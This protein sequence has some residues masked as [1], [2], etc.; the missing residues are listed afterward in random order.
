[1]ADMKV[2]MTLTVQDMGTVKL[3]QFNDALKSVGDQVAALNDRFKAAIAGASDF[4]KATSDAA[5]G[6]TTLSR[7]SSGAS[8]STGRLGD[9]L[10]AMQ[11]SLLALNE[12]LAAAVDNIS[13]MAAST[14]DL[15]AASKGAAAGIAAVGD[16]AEGAGRKAQAAHGS[17]KPLVELFA[18]FKGA[19]MTAGADK[20]ASK[21]QQSMLQLRLRNMTPEQEG[22]AKAGARQ[23]SKL[24]FINRQQALDAE[25]ISQQALPGQSQFSQGLRAKL[26]P[27][28]AK[29]AFITQ[30]Y[31]PRASF[32]ESFGN[33][34]GIVD[35]TG[36]ADNLQRAQQ[37]L[38]VIRAALI[39]TGGKLDW[40]GIETHFR[41]E[42]AATRLNM[43][44][45]ELMMELSFMDD[46][47]AFG[48]AGAG[49]NTRIGT[50]ANN[51]RTT[52][53]TGKIG[54][55]AAVMLEQLR[56]LKASDTFIQGKSNSYVYL[57]PDALRN[58]QHAASSPME[59]IV[60]TLVPR[61]LRYTQ[62]HWKQFGYK[63]P[64]A[65]NFYNP[66]EASAALASAATYFASMGAG[67][68]Q[69]AYGI[70]EA[71]SPGALAPVLSQMHAMHEAMKLNMDQDLKM[72]LH[73]QHGT[74]EELKAQF[75]N[76]GLTI[77][78]QL[79]P[80][81]T[82]L[83]KGLTAILTKIN[84]VTQ[85]LPAIGAALAAIL[86]A[87]T[88]WTGYK[89]ITGL[90]GIVKHFKAL[91][92]STEV[93]GELAEK[94]S[95]KVLTMA[96][97]I[98]FAAGKMTLA[99]GAALAAGYGLGTLI[100]DLINASGRAITGNKNWSLGSQIYH[101]THAAPGS[102]AQLRHAAGAPIGVRF[103]N[104][105]DLM[106]GG[107]LAHY[108]NSATGLA[109]MALL[110]KGPMYA[111]GGLDTISQIVSKY[112]PHRNAA[113]QI[114]NHTRSYISGVASSMRIGANAKINL[115]DPA[116]LDH[117]MVGMLQQEGTLKY[118]N[119]KE[120]QS[121][122]ATIARGRMGSLSA[123][124]FAALTPEER[125]MHSELA[126]TGAMHISS[127]TTVAGLKIMEGVN[128]KA[129][130][131]AKSV[132]AHALKLHQEAEAKLSAAFQR[133]IAAAE[134]FQ[135]KLQAI[136]DNIHT[137]YA[138]IF[139][140]LSSQI[141]A[142]R[143]KY[144]GISGELLANG[145]A[146]AAKEALA[147]G[148]HQILGLQYHGAIAHLKALQ[149]NLH[150]AITGNAA[151]VTA[152]SMTKMQAGQADIALQKQMAPQMVKAAEAALQYAKALKDPALIQSLTEQIA[153]LQAMGKELGY[154]STKVKN[155]M[156]DGLTG[157]FENLMHGQKTWGQMFEQLFA[158]IGKSIENTLAK[159][160]SQSITDSLMGKKANQGIGSIIGGIAQ[161]VGSLFGGSSSGAPNVGAT[162]TSS[163]GSV[164]SDISAGGGFLKDLFS[165]IG[166]FAVGADNI[167]N[168]MVAQIHK[169]EMIIPAGP[170]E[171]IR[172]GASA[173][174]TL[175][176]TVHAM[177]SQSVMGALHSVRAEATQLFMNTAQHL[178]YNG[179]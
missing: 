106:P 63:A 83:D 177:D 32:R 96:K 65:A 14:A 102:Y 29:L 121:V 91:S 174:H 82:L 7:A 54:K 23:L 64:T 53:E 168:D 48:G 109:Q 78:K 144:Q 128:K 175:N 148:Q 117:L 119:P 6:V 69:M 110:L 158:G 31:N 84:A 164:W 134:R 126:K 81:I 12:K 59:Y 74:W 98:A 163:S 118:Y 131:H 105:G 34:A 56:L 133:R 50:L 152:G 137:A 2:A 87:G 93:A 72:A 71:G 100:N 176:L 9:M 1:M 139:N 107:H 15:S 27:D 135:A 75:S 28:I 169:G 38:N 41:M 162:A 173:G 52:A 101:W 92:G 73:T 8:R 138:G 67:G 19:E 66:K 21:Y 77:G 172:S 114:I 37:V 122:A 115:N 85:A 20:L 45:N 49:G 108:A 79:V 68:Q 143:A 170:A 16:A 80:A 104:P 160:I 3:Q 47:K 40:R 159:S 99:G 171:A 24:P 33:I 25:I 89:G 46:M 11:D 124:S 60:G 43:P 145:H 18:A 129:A 150:Q 157:F 36:G 178:N 61:L 165:V 161:W 51:L 76:L 141:P 113:G 62:V 30:T 142:V 86:V 44:M 127:Q 125:V 4:G 116:T 39:A 5:D 10:K 149:G 58:A 167:P 123:T 13:A 70:A 97:N 155:S 146:N 156:Q 94:A 120:I 151:L 57:N 136:A 35:A 88:A 132:A 166:S 147:V 90:L 55:G 140:P 17:L 95:P 179:G 103:N 22:S 130:A 112:A 111:G 153:K 42:S 26:N 154:Y